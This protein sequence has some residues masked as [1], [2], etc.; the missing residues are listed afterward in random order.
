MKRFLIFLLLILS[1]VTILPVMAEG[2]ATEG[3]DDDPSTNEE[4]LDLM[5]RVA[6]YE[7]PEKEEPVHLVVGNT[8]KVSGGFFTRFFGNNTSD[9][10]VRSMIYGYT[11]T[12]WDNQLQFLRDENVVER[13]TKETN[14][15]A[16]TYT[17][18]LTKDLVYCD[19]ETKITAKDY[20]F[21]WVLSAAPEFQ[22]IGG[23]APEV[24]VVGYEDF[25]SGAKSWYEGIRLIDDYTFS[26]TIKRD[27]EPYFYEMHQLEMYPYPIS[28]IAP[29]CEVRDDGKGAYITGTDGKRSAFSAELL[30][31][32]ILDPENGYRSHPMLTSGPYRLVSYDFESG[33][34][35]FEINP[36]YKGNYEGVKP[37]IDTVTLVPV[38]PENVIQKLEDGEIGLFNK[39]VDSDVILDGFRLVGEG[40]FEMENY[41]RMGYG[42]C[43]F[44]TEKNGPQQFMAVRQAL[45]YAFDSDSF[46]RQTLG[47]FGINVYGYY[48]LAQWMFRAANGNYRP[49][50][51]SEEE[52]EA[53]D[54]LTLENLNLY[55]LDLDEANRLLDED[56]WTL[57]ADGGTYDP[58]VD[59]IRYKEVNGELMP[60]ILKFAQCADNAAARLV[61]DM[62]AETLP[63]IGAA[64]DVDVI[65]FH[66]LLMDY[67]RDGG[68]RKYDMN[69]MA[70]NFVATFDPYLVF[71]QN[72]E[73]QGSVNTSGIV[74]DELVD[75]AFDMRHTDPGDLFTFEERWIKMQE[76]YNEVLPT[77]P[78]YTNIYFD[79]HTDWLQ[80][81]FPNAEYSWPMAILYAFYA[82][83]EEPEEEEEEFGG[84]DEFFDDGEESFE[85]GGE[86]FEDGGSSF[87]KTGDMFEDAGDYFEGDKTTADPETPGPEEKKS[88]YVIDEDGWFLQIND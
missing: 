3:N 54:E 26:V 81:Y 60:L 79:F 34:V 55:P 88:P 83:P 19:G 28:V 71:L 42:F 11:P 23:E 85:D 70:T 68:E 56:G 87:E 58:D 51:L 7:R 78:I 33:V 43:A 35:E 27:F 24:N 63:Q 76:R 44:S 72:E 36:Y 64:L 8:T 80:N 31:K 20:V 1:L 84:G 75:L 73:L 32:T 17:F 6:L 39:A 48:G 45:N 12:T 62:Y 49:G 82:E 52:E 37:W 15:D 59:E 41:P 13:L 69:F 25:H 22:A 38:L 86:F 29:G 53:W 67:Y 10:D 4:E 46:V 74:D 14:D 77:M 50:D 30:Q 61:V 65:P 5:V 21:S 40:G 2:G 18:Y 16:V 66:D 9:I 57:N 47:G